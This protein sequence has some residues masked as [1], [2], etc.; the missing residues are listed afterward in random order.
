MGR[1]ERGGGGTVRGHGKGVE[2]LGLGT[3]EE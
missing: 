3:S 1:G 2:A